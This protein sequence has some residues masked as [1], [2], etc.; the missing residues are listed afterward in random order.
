MIARLQPLWEFRG[1]LDWITAIDELEDGL[2]FV[3]T[4][5]G[6]LFV[7]NRHGAQLGHLKLDSWVG[8]L[9]AVPPPRNG[10]F[11]NQAFLFVGTKGGDLK[12]MTVEQGTEDIVSLQEL[13][14]T[15]K[16]AGA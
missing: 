10:L 14:S 4:R 1:S 2:I 15:P 13:F 7:L 12:C 8:A 9:C 5:D 11:G 16:H 6:Q 3:G